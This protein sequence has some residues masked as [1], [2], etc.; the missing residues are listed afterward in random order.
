[1]C[2]KNDE[3]NKDEIE[4]IQGFKSQLVCRN[5]IKSKSAYLI[6]LLLYLNSIE[7]RQIR[8]SQNF[9]LELRLENQIRPDFH[10]ISEAITILN[11]CIT[12]I[13]NKIKKIKNIAVLK[14]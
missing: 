11:E 5:N 1:M 8:F 3:N 12:N 9:E 13:N 6:I 4:V 10:L 2:T 7:I 14:N